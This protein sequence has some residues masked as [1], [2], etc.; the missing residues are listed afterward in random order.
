MKKMGSQQE[1]YKMENRKRG[2]EGRWDDYLKSVIF[3]LALCDANVIAFCDTELSVLE[4]GTVHMSGTVVSS[5][6]VI[7][8]FMLAADF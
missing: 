3:Y 1:K 4:R 7:N 2:A 5:V 8:A 6:H